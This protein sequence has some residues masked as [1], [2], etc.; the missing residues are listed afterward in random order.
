MIRSFL[1]VPGDSER[2]QIKALEGDADAL[3]LDLEDSVAPADKARAREVV[4]AAIRA[5]RERGPACWVRVNPLGSA[6]LQEDLATVVSARPDGIVLPKCG[7]ACDVERLSALIRPLEAVS[8]FPDGSILILPIVTETAAGV[9]AAATYRDRSKRLFGL[10]WGAEDLA[11]DLGAG[12]KRYDDGRYRDAFRLARSVT[13]LG[14]VA[15][16]VEPIDTVFPDFRND[17]AF[18]EECREAAIDGF[19]GKMAIHPA[20]VSII[21][22]AFTPSEEEVAEARMI[23]E[24]FGAAGDPGVLAVDGRML[25][26]PHLL[27]ARRVIARTSSG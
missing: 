7:H 16:N 5:K 23:V 26:R 12:R 17:E 3:I 19:T 13:L 14:A 2:K 10:T 9:L 1:F 21:N 11:T 25:D 24:A 27:Q 4:A 20:Q 22:E 18:A 6:F 15:A 8:N